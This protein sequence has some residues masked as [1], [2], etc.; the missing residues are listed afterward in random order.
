MQITES[1]VGAWTVLKLAGKLEIKNADERKQVGRLNDVRASR[2]ETKVLLALEELTEAMNRGWAARDSR[3]A[4][5]LQE[6]R[7][8]VTIK[9]DRARLDAIT[10]SDVIEVARPNPPASQAPSGF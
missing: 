8:G 3:V 5:V 6:E 2:D 1:K 10:A 4:M 9:A 7:A